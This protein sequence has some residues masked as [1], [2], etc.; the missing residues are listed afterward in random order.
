MVSLDRA[1]P[2]SGFSWARIA[3]SQLTDSMDVKITHVNTILYTNTPKS[4]TECV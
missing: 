1:G 2:N 4:S 3:I